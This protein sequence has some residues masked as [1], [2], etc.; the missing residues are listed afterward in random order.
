MVTGLI[1]NLT[2]TVVCL[3][4][5]HYIYY[6]K[7]VPLYSPVVIGVTVTVRDDV[8]SGSNSIF[9]NVTSPMKTHSMFGS[10]H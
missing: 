8:G 6:I 7:Q 5:D 9:M 10:G 4:N 2:V 3:K 1:L